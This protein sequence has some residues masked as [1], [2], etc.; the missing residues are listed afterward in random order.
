MVTFTAAS[1]VRCYV[2][3][4]GSE[5]GSAR[6][7]VIGPITAAAARSAGVRVDVEAREYTVPGLLDAICEYFEREEGEEHN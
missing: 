7:A 1:T 6:V 4:A 5:L 3:E 2:D